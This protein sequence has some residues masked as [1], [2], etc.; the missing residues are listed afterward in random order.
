MDIRNSFHIHYEWQCTCF[1]AHETFIC[2]ISS[3]CTLVFLNLKLIQSID[4]S[5]L[6][7]RKQT[8]IWSPSWMKQKISLDRWLSNDNYLILI[9]NEHSVRFSHQSNEFSVLF[10][11][12]FDQRSFRCLSWCWYSLDNQ[13]KSFCRGNTSIK[14]RIVL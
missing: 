8:M 13:A 11:S 14:I 1:L 9:T 4:L 5:K 7:P 10:S 3:P 12:S 6:N 2:S